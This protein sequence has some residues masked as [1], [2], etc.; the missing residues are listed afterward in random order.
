MGMSAGLWHRGA[1]HVPMGWE[2]L[3]SEGEGFS[4]KVAARGTWGGEGRPACELQEHFQGLGP[5]TDLGDRCL[6][7]L[8]PPPHISLVSPSFHEY[9]V[10]CF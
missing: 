8:R 3:C 1:G 7:L 9:K 6:C 10:N 4:E 2:H 5:E